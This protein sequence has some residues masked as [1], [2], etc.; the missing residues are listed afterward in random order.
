MQLELPFLRLL[1]P[2]VQLPDQPPPARDPTPPV[3]F[4]RVVRARRY[5]VRVKP[6]GTVRVTVPRSG[7]KREAQAFLE[8][9]R[10]WIERERRRV[11]EQHAPLEWRDGTVIMLRGNPVTID[12]D[13]DPNRCSARYGDRLVALDAHR[14]IRSQ[15]E[16]DLCALA[17]HE[18]VP[19]LHELADAHGVL[20]RRVLIRNQRSRWGSCS[21]RG[22]IALNFRLVQMPSH[23]RDYVLLHELMHV[24]QQNHSRRFWRLVEAACPWFRDAERWL[25]VQGKALF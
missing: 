17:Q 25:K 19:R 16:S 20:V 7:S 6:D 9:Q 24:R 22:T 1:P 11:A 2:G 13:T 12:V 8:K 5:I 3:E 4:V 21:R 18:L 23:V 14:P 10:R 15:I